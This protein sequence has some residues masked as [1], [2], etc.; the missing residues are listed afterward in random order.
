L[1]ATTG[2]RWILKDGYFKS[3]FIFY[4]NNNQHGKRAKEQI[5]KASHSC[6]VVRVG[7]VLNCRL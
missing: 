3:I 1:A 5:F 6:D 7:V 4:K 2:T